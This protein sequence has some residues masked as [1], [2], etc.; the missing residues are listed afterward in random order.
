MKQL[1]SIVLVLAVSLCFGQPELSREGNYSGGNRS[2]SGTYQLNSAF[3]QSTSGLATSASFG[4]RSGLVN[5]ST[6]SSF[7]TTWQTTATNESIT[8]PTFSGETYDYIVDWG[9]GTFESITTDASPSHTYT[10]AGTHTISISGTFPRIHFNNTGDFDKIQTIE[11][12]GDIAWT[13]FEGAFES[14]LNLTSNASDAPDLSGV[15]SLSQMF[16]GS[17]FNGAVNAWDVSSITDMSELFLATNFNQPLDGWDVSNVIDMRGM[18]FGNFT[19]N[20]DIGDWDVSAVTNMSNMFNGASSFNQDLSLWGVGLVT[21]MAGMFSGTAFNQDVGGWDVSAVRDMSLMFNSSSF[22]Q[23]LGDWD[24]SGVVADGGATSFSMSQMFDGSGMSTD[25]YDATLLGWADDNAGTQTIPAGITLGADGLNFCGSEA[26]R[27]ELLN[28]HG[29][30]INGD[31]KEC[32]PNDGLVAYYPFSGDATDASGSGKDGTL[33]DGSTTSTFPALASDRFENAD[34]AYSFD[35]ADDYILAPAQQFDVVNDPFTIITWVNWDGDISSQSQIVS[36]WD[37]GSAGGAFMYLGI[38]ETSGNIMVGDTWGDTGVP[39]KANEWVQVVA[40]FDGSNANLYLNGE[41]VAT[42]TGRSYDLSVGNLY[43]GRQGTVNDEY[44]G[45]SIDDIRIYNRTLTYAEIQDLYAENNWL[46]SAPS[47]FITT[48]QTTSDNES[49]N[50]P[51]GLD[52]EIYDY[53]VDW[54]DGTVESGFTADANHT[55]AIAGTY[56]VAISGTFPRIFFNSG[57]AGQHIDKIQSVE[58]WGDITWT[59]MNN[60]F[61]G[62]TNLTYNA[63]DAPD[64]GA[65]TNITHMFLNCSSFNGD[66][67]NW[68]VSGVT[69]MNGMFLGAT[70]F[71]GNIS[72]WNVSQVTDM[73]DMFNNTPFTGDLSAWDVSSLTRMDGMFGGASSFNADISGWNVSSVQNM[74]RL[75]DGASSFDQNLRNWDISSVTNSISIFDNSGMSTANFDRT[76]LGWADDNGGSEIIPTGI[77]FGASG[78]AYC[79]SGPARDELIANYSWT[80]SGD[81]EN[82]ASP[83]LDLP[84]DGD[85]L[86]ASGYGFDPSINGPLTTMDRSGD[87]GQAYSF[88]GVDDYMEIP[89]ADFAG[90]SENLTFSWWQNIDNSTDFGDILSFGNIRAYVNNGSLLVISVANS[91]GESISTEVSD[92]SWEHFVFTYDGVEVRIY[93]NG[94]LDN[95]QPRVGKIDTNN[96]LAFIGSLEDIDNYLDGSVDQIKVYRR[97]FSDIEVQELFQSESPFSSET[98][99]TSFTIPNQVGETVIDDVA[100]T[101]DV[102]M[103]FGT[104]VTALTPTIEISLNA[105]VS[106][107]SETA[108]DFSNPVTYTVT[109]ED[110]VTTQEWVVTV[111]VD[112]NEA[113]AFTAFSFAEQTGSATIGDGTILVE[114]ANGTDLTNLVSTFSL[115]TGASAVVGV[116]SQVSGSTSN[117]FTNP[118]TYTVTAEDGVTTQDWVVTVF[119]ASNTATEILAFSFAEQTGPATIGNGMI[120]IEVANGTD[121]SSLIASFTLSTGATA[122]IGG[123]SQQSGVTANDFSNPLTYIITAADNATTEEWIVNVTEALNSA[124]EIL[125]FS[126]SEQTSPATIGDGTVTVEVANGTNLTNLIASFTL[127]EGAKVTISGTDQES[128]VTSNDFSSPVTYSVTAADNVTTEDWLV[129]V[130]EASNT[131]TEILAY[132]FDEQTGPANITDGVIDIEVAFGTDVSNL[133]ASFNLSS[134]ANAAIAG[135]TQE[136]GITANDFSSEVTYTVTAADNVTTQDWAVDVSVSANDST[137]ILSFLIASTEGVIDRDQHTVILSMPSGTDLSSLTPTIFVSTNATI[138]PASGVAQN[139]SSPVTYTV[140]SENAIS[141]EWVVTA[142]VES[143]PPESLFL[144]NSSITAGPSGK[145]V[146][147]I[148]IVDEDNTIDDYTLSITSGSENFEIISNQLVTKVELTKGD[149]SVTVQ[150]D[151]PGT[152]EETFAITAIDASDIQNAFIQIISSLGREASNYRIIGVPAESVGINEVFTVPD[153]TNLG[154]EGT[155]RLLNY[156]GGSSRDLSASSR[157]Q[158]GDGYWFIST[159]APEVVLPDNG[160]PNLNESGEFELVLNAGWNLVGNPFNASWNWGD[161]ISYNVQEAYIESGDVQAEFIK[162]IPMTSAQVG[163]VTESEIKVFEGGWVNNTSGSTL[164]VYIPTPAS[165]N[166]GRVARSDNSSGYFNSPFDWEI[167]VDVIGEKYYSSLSGIAFKDGS[168]IGLDRLDRQSPPAIDASIRMN[169]LDAE[170]GTSINRVPH[171]EDFTWDFNLDVT[172]GS[173]TT[174]KWDQ[175]LVNQV[176]NPLYMIIPENGQIID[177]QA[178]GQVN[179]SSRTKHVQIH[180]GENPPLPGMVNVLAAYPNPSEDVVYVRVLAHESLTNEEATIQLFDHQGRVVKTLDG[181]TITNRGN[182]F[183]LDLNQLSSGIYMLQVLINDQKSKNIKIQRR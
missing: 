104:D 115:S 7:I 61:A 156:S 99:I 2:S 33:G 135:L 47:S 162:W 5:T 87:S 106:P 90:G 131:A 64:L 88:D 77:V 40:S 14:C 182:E 134:G 31:L 69:T 96:G 150:A 141:Q 83:V 159:I 177:M 58:Q 82:C 37:A 137:D 28:T 23:D 53:T 89:N 60:A 126:F 8:I 120:A 66:L 112:P 78:L 86:D 27:D 48:W 32:T 65:V 70:S 145:I 157:L 36:W 149:Y 167:G 105:S 173:I 155:W 129:T 43:V 75:F 152:I 72:T 170:N 103:P 117:D 13:S 46:Q 148:G 67:N 147:D 111:T 154:K 62:C 22:N 19:F 122:T 42:E 165:L 56:S 68:D 176:G 11:Q 108:Q 41:L 153:V 178:V 30:T 136:S 102:S 158:G 71:N 29:W 139:F 39:L 81:A 107:E 54:G 45:G 73:A 57:G 98:F 130:F 166:S 92:G 174:L 163:Y 143:I 151:G 183:E 38:R 1:L 133:I 95:S 119:E 179:V 79:L 12:W 52:G 109:A 168:S 164:T 138:A 44:Y 116:T 25:N 101:L 114:V 74:E 24:I 59:S 18:F 97:T 51:I 100:N 17:S 172:D 144:S 55:Y 50:I 169:L 161:V 34:A 171:T 21:N 6:T 140:T 91:T 142:R 132:S 124:T 127:S 85:S 4:L 16:R 80:I 76:L 113:T 180:Y 20:Q 84:F 26:A 63:T 125:T 15:T 121:L 10:T 110:G 181:Q 146:G 35:G 94:A 9:D 118:V 128:G 3:G 160:T 123:T 175:S 49:I 93:K